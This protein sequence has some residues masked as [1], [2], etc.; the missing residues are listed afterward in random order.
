MEQAVLPQSV[1]LEQTQHVASWDH[2]LQYMYET[3]CY[4]VSKV[5]ITK[6]FQIMIVGVLFFNIQINVE[7][8]M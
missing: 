5:S 8:L 4:R 3:F 6:T 7:F 2:K 1:F